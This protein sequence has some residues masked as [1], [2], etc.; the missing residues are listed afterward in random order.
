MNLFVQIQDP[1]NI[2]TG[3]TDAQAVKMALNLGFQGALTAQVHIVIC[4]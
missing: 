3:V 4:V 1:I 2:V